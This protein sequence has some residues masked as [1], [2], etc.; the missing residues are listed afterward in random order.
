MGT[1]RAAQERNH[2]AEFVDGYR[3]VPSLV[4]WMVTGRCSGSCEHC[5]TSAGR[6]VGEM[7]GRSVERFLDDLAEMGIDEL[8]V[9]G[10]EP[11][12]RPDLAGLISAIAQRGLRWSLNTA[13]APGPGLLRAMQAW[14]PCFVAVSLDGPAAVHDRIRGWPGAFDEALVAIRTLSELTE[15]NVA[16]GT[17]VSR[18]TFP[19][20]TETFAVV[21][22]SGASSWGLHLVVPEGRASGRDD[23]LLSRQQ[24]RSLIRFAADK[25]KYFPVTMADEV[26]YCGSWEPLVRDTPFFCGAGRTHCVVLPDGDVVPCTTFDRSECGGNVTE[27]PLSEIWPLAFSRLRRGGLD[28]VCRTCRLADACGGGCWL[29]RRH[30]GHCYRESWEGRAWA[31]PAALAVGLG[32]AACSRPPASVDAPSAVEVEEPIKL[33]AAPEA[34]A[35]APTSEATAPEGTLTSSAATP[36]NDIG[37]LLIRWHSACLQGQASLPNVEARLDERVGSDPVRPFLERLLTGA[38][39]PAWA[40]RAS[41]VRA[42]TRSSQRSLHLVSLLWRDVALWCFDGP[43]VE[44]RSESDRLLLRETMA[45]L[46]RTAKAWREEIFAAKLDPFL[47]RDDP[48]FR[49]SFLSKAGPP[50]HLVRAMRSSR[51]HWS[52]D[53]S[54]AVTHAWLQAHPFAES[55]ELELRLPPGSSMRVNDQP[56]PGVVQVGLFDVVA[57]GPGPTGVRV[58]HR[59]RWLSVR[60]PASALISHPDLLRLVYEQNGA[61]LDADVKGD[62]SDLTEA[63]L[64]PALRALVERLEKAGPA[65]ELHQARR[66]LFDAWLF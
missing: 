7:D 22:A 19:H 57:V 28:G 31:A 45:T 51:K 24:V 37:P 2:A 23:L 14:P 52:S 46:A 43:S 26:G 53:G 17:T 47:R 58:K 9:T 59:G 65:N 33:D 32:L 66:R 30:G 38:Q 60:L 42:A 64:L 11:L 4:Q 56:T 12:E 35:L 61:T 25:R 13:R 15:G 49:R 34:S 41:Q 48:R 40:Q 1:F 39:P 3:R 10:G 16:A 21:L 18:R 5:M 44:T 63:L 55:I 29:Q 36:T 62:G 20:L 50:R 6:R 8:L 54:A 27:M